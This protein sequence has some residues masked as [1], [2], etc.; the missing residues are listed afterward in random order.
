[1]NDDDGRYVGQKQP[2]TVE[3]VRQLIEAGKAVARE[4]LRAKVQALPEFGDID[5]VLR[6]DV[7]ALIDEAAP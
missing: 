2:I 5:C 7:L 1:M 3:E 6:D 4:E